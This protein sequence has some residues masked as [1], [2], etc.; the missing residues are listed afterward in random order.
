MSVNEKI[1]LNKNKK[2]SIEVLVDR[3]VVNPNILDRITESV[4]LALKLGN[5][6]IIIN[7]LPS[8][9]YI[10]SENFACPD[11]QI[12]MEEIVPR[13]FSFNSPYGACETCDGLGSHMEVDPN[14]VVPDKG[15]SLTQ[16]AKG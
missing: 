16:G 6:L 7:E 5:G 1:R 14:M 3:I 9:E 4:E 13:M 8:K 10:F 2:H 11:C 12:S 15:K